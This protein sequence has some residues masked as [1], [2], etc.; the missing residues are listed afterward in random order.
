MMNRWTNKYSYGPGGAAA[1]PARAL[2]GKI[3]SVLL[4]VLLIAVIALSIFGGRAIVYQSKC[5]PSFIYRMQT[6]CKEAVKLMDSL[7]RSSGGKAADNATLARIRANV[8][9]IDAINEINNTVEG[10]NGYLVPPTVFTELYS[11]IER[12]YSH[13]SQEGT[14]IEDQNILTSALAELNALLIELD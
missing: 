11:I 8:H 1:T 4:V 5:A 10:G 14:P 6:E 7:S 12:Y 2:G 3:R 13:L 9:A